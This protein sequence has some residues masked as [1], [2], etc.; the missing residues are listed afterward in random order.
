MKIFYMNQGGGGHWGAVKYS[1]YDL[2]LLAECPDP[3]SKFKVT[4]ASKAKPTMSVQVPVD[5]SARVITDAKDLD[6]TVGAVRPLVSFQVTN[7][8]FRVVFFHL[9]SGSERVASEELK[10]AVG[11]LNTLYDLKF[12]TPILWVGDFNR[13]V[14][15][16]IAAKFGEV[17][18]IFEGGGYAGWHLDRVLTTGDWRPLVATAE[19]VTKAALDHNHKGIAITIAPG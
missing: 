3:K 2:L 18:T 17:T 11:G 4:Y 7:P 14:D 8:N 15:D 9:K 1:Q 6:T 16:E 13:A 10:K 12:Q 19:E 5:R